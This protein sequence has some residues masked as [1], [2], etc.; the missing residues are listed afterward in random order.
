MPYFGP[1]KT[2]FKP[3][4]FENDADEFN[5]GVISQVWRVIRKTEISGIVWKEL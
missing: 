4:A 1:R 2:Y 5:A 3:K